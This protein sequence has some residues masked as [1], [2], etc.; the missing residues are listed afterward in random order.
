[1]SAASCT[2]RVAST[3]P[4]AG[5]D[6]KEILHRN[7]DDLVAGHFTY[8]R[9]LELVARK[10]YC[11]G[12]EGDVERYTASCAVCAKAKSCTQKPYRESQS[13]PTPTGPWS[14]ISL[15]FIVGLL[16]SRHTPKSKEKNSILVVVNRYSNMV[17][18][19]PVTD[20]IDAPGLV[21]I[22][23]RKL[24]LKGM[25]FPKSIVSD[26]GPRLTYKFWS[27]LCFYL[28]IRRCMSSAY[29]PLTDGLTERQNRTLEQYLCSYINY[30]H[31]DWVK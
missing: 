25:G 13:L 4:P 28:R 9:T 26:H 15:D 16:L 22:L 6:R 1:M 17:R 23:A 8:K 29:H 5:D 3:Y 12:L 7:H 21:D 24:V 27:A 18:Y 11:P 2:G 19:F 20:G 10:Y 30:H 14:D 31:D